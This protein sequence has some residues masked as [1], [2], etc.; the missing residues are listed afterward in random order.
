MSGDGS[1][2]RGD[3]NKGSLILRYRKITQNRCDTKKK[4]VEP[5]PAPGLI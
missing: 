4:N 3:K 2:E 1:S 5:K